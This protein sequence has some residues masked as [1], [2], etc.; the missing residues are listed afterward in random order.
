M[1][2]NDKITWFDDQQE[3]H[4]E[5]LWGIAPAGGIEVAV[6]E[7]LYSLVR[8]TKPLILVEA[9]TGTFYS[10]AYTLKGIV[11]NGVGFLHT[12]DIA[13]SFKE[14]DFLEFKG[15]HK[16][17]LAD[18]LKEGA[19][20]V[21]NLHGESID[22]IFL[23]SE[24]TY[25]Q[26]MGEFNLF[27]PYLREGGLITFH[28]TQH[29]SGV[30]KAVN[31][32]SQRDDIAII[33]LNTPRGFGIGV[34]IKPKGQESENATT[35]KKRVTKHVTIIMYCHSSELPMIDSV[36]LNIEE[37]TQYEYDLFIISDSDKIT[38][39]PYDY[40]YL[41]TDAD[42]YKS[43]NRSMEEIKSEYVVFLTPNITVHDKWLTN[44]M[45]HT[46]STSVVSPRIFTKSS[47]FFQFYENFNLTLV[48][49][50]NDVGRRKDLD[51]QTDD[52]IWL[53]YW[54]VNRENFL[55]EGGWCTTLDHPAAMNVETYNK[56]KGTLNFVRALD[57]KILI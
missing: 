17:H 7:L 38:F 41:V 5:G 24:H 6:G 21:A 40:E 54:L 56:Y 28:D 20:F 1:L 42:K 49:R 30:T 47:T 31:E 27:F 18:S 43:W 10:A 8:A 25:E 51:D 39:L 48:K 22:F 53:N 33:C 34:K 37:H 11:D 2:I 32:I 50:L 9:G 13:H 14:E 4:R 55:K 3:K 12:F 45:K 46:N 29:A 23:D 15:K 26:V 36:L 57:S 19:T 16:F 35:K 44:M 52:N